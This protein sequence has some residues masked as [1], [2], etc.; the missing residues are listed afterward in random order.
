MQTTDGSQNNFWKVLLGIG[1]A[2]VLFDALFGEEGKKSSSSKNKKVFV[3]FAVEDSKYRDFMVAQAK[4]K[5]SPFSFIDMSI[6]Q[7]WSEGEWKRN[8]RKK[9]KDSDGVIVL[10]S[11]HTYHAGG[12]RWEIKCADEENVPIMGIHVRK[13]DKYSIPPELSKRSVKEWSWDNISNFI[14]SL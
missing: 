12:A 1:A 3:S 8:C 10:L 9:I 7:P 13:D 5:R 6:K 2:A 4:N 11:N 14:D